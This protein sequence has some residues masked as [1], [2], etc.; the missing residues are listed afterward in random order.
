MLAVLALDNLLE[1]ATPEPPAKVLELLRVRERARQTRDYEEADSV[2]ERIEA[3]GWEVRDGPSGP[4]L[5]P[6]QR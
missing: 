6:A 5:L 1:Q 4:E 2:R 3:M